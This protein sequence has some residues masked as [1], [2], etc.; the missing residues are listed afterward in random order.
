MRQLPS[1]LS[2]LL[3]AVAGRVV[4]G[5]IDPSCAAASKELTQCLRSKVPPQECLASSSP[6]VK[7]CLDAEYQA[8]AQALRTAVANLNNSC[9]VALEEDLSSAESAEA[10]LASGRL[11][12][13]F[14]LLIKLL[15]DAASGMSRPD[16]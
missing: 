12:T 15:G 1:A 13:F 14:G 10:L 6:D 3:L 11:A 7:A 2:W 8:L 16:A 5:N 9:A 4:L